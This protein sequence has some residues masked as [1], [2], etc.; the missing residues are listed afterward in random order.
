MLID[1]PDYI[2]TPWDLLYF[3]WKCFFKPSDIKWIENNVIVIMKIADT[4]IHSNDPI[5]W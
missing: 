2:P 4:G 3:R 5:S 1:I